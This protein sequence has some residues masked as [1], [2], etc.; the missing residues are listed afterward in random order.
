MKKFIFILSILISSCSSNPEII[1]KMEPIQDENN[2][3]RITNIITPSRTNTYIEKEMDDIN[4]SIR[5]VDKIELN[6]MAPDNSP[7]LEPLLSTFKMIIQNKRETKIEFNI[8]NAIILDGLGNQYQALSYE[9]FKSLYPATIYQQY[10]Y[11][12]VFN[13]YQKESYLTD[14]YHKR[15]EVARTLFRGGKIYPGV[16]VE[17]LLPFERLTNYSSD[18]TLILSDIKLYYA[19]DD[20]DKDIKEEIKKKLEFKFKFKHKIIRLKK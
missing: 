1:K 11:S 20:S 3:Y 8:K 5:Y 4:I 12:F 2:T 7:Y 9:D 17:G 14:D 18:I 16:T 10:E 19:K 15:K 6:S 13:R